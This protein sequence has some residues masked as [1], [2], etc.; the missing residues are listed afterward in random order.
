VAVP[1]ALYLRGQPQFALA[2]LVM[3]ALVFYKHRANIERLMTGTESRIGA[4]G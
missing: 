4:K 2:F 3:S 1:V